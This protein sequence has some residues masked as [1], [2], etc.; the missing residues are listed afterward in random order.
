MKRLL[1]LTLVL[2]TGCSQGF[3]TE[4]AKACGDTCKPNGVMLFVD[5]QTPTCICNQR[6]P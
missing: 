2:T 1:I 4:R 5:T 3:Y 6:S